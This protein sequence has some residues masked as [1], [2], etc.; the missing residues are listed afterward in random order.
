MK[1]QKTDVLLYGEYY[2]ILKTK[3]HEKDNKNF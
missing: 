2:K 3:N 1:T